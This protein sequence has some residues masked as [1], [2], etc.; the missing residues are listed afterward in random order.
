MGAAG[1]VGPVGVTLQFALAHSG[2]RLGAVRRELNL[3]HRRARAP[4]LLDTVE[5]AW[6][7][8]S[9]RRDSTRAFRLASMCHVLEESECSNL[10]G[11]A[12]MR[13]YSSRRDDRRFV[14]WWW[15]IPSARAGALSY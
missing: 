13:R 9:V 2:A 11:A 12:I 3:A 8:C 5:R 15:A 4:R 7:R 1:C 10:T 14:R 6:R